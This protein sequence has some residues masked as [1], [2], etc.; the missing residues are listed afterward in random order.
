MV[1]QQEEADDFYLCRKR[2]RSSHP[3]PSILRFLLLLL[4]TYTRRSCFKPSSR[5]SGRRSVAF[6]V[7][8][9]QGHNVT[10]VKPSPEL[11]AFLRQRWVDRSV[12]SCAFGRARLLLTSY[13]CFV[14]WPSICLSLSHRVWACFIAYCLNIEYVRAA[15]TLRRAS[16]HSSARNCRSSFCLVRWLRAE[17]AANLRVWFFNFLLRAF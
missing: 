9:L 2:G 17:L 5:C 14:R 15:R 1:P 10:Q 4:Y 7:V 12:H 13:P 6:N 11:P 16:A 8:L 3:L